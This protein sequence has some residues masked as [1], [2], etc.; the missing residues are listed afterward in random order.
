M[1]YV[2]IECGHY[3]GM[4]VWVYKGYGMR[5]HGPECF[6]GR[7]TAD[8]GILVDYDFLVGHERLDYH[9][10][11]VDLSWHTVDE[12]DVGDGLSSGVVVVHCEIRIQ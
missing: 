6:C 1:G 11:I 8:W 2:C 9:L 3:L 12:Y 5:L 10:C 7:V 4:G